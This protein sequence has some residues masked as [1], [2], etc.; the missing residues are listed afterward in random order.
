MTDA[1]QAVQEAAASIPAEVCARFDSAE[2]L[3]DEDR[4]TIVQIARNV[5]ARFQPK[6][7]SNAKSKP[8]AAAKT[9]AESK[10]QS[11][12]VSQP[13]SKAPTEVEPKPK[14]MPKEKS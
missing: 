13:D 7:E 11:E 3:S 14:P 5:L 12:S 2:T 1:E 10:P 9:K 8:E 4:A 6:P